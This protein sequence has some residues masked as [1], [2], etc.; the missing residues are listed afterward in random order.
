ML[1]SLVQLIT[2]LFEAKNATQRGRGR[3]GRD[4]GAAG[5]GGGVNMGILHSSSTAPSWLSCTGLL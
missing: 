2:V 5:G 1:C 3:E 4:M